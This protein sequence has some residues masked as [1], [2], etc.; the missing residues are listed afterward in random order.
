LGFLALFLRHLNSVKAAPASARPQQL[1]D[2]ELTR[3]A[4]SFA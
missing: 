3:L 4:S 2:D 1:G